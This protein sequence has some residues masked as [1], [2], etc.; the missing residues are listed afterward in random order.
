MISSAIGMSIDWAKILKFGFKWP[1]FR[2][3]DD[4]KDRTD[5]EIC[6]HNVSETP[7]RRDNTPAESDAGI[8]RNSIG[9]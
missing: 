4:R 9:K 6:H 1:F 2:H 3:S 8:N 7:I 5:K